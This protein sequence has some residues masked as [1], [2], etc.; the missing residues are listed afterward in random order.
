MNKIPR[1]LRDLHTDTSI[2]SALLQ[3]LKI[4]ATLDVPLDTH[5]VDLID[6]TIKRC[7]LHANELMEML[8]NPF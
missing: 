7:Q 2:Q 3:V 5:I 4:Q 1:P 6:R 8:V